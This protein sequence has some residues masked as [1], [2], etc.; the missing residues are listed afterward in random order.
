MR[1]YLR[2]NPSPKRQAISWVIAKMCRYNISLKDIAEELR[3]MAR[4]VKP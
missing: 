3:L 2:N 1:K 4:Q